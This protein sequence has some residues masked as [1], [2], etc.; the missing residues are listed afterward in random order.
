MSGQGKSLQDIYDAGSRKLDE[1]EQTE[2]SKLETNALAAVEELGKVETSI[3][4]RMERSVGELDAEIRSYLDK[5]VENIKTAVS[6]EVEENRKFLERLQEALKLSCKSLSED[7]KQL[8]ESMMQRFDSTAD[9]YMTLQKRELEKGISLLKTEGS[10]SAAKLKEQSQSGLTAF[11]SRRAGNVLQILD[12]NIKVP[13]EFFAEFSRHAVSIDK[14]INDCL[15]LLSSRSKEISQDLNS[16]GMEMQRSLDQVVLQLVAE[17]ED[18]AKKSDAQLRKHCEDALSQALMYQEQISTKLSKELQ[19]SYQSSGSGIAEKMTAL[20]RDTDKLLE[21]VKQ[22][23]TDVDNGVRQNCTELGASFETSLNERLA[24]AR[25]HNKLV[26]D[27]RNQLM[28]SIAGD[29][30]EIESNFESRL[31]ELAQK[32][33]ARLSAVCVDAEVAITSAH[34]ACAAEFKSLSSQQQKTIEEKT[35]QLLDE[36]ETKCNQA[37]HTIKIAA[38]DNTPEAGS[39]P[40]QQVSAAEQTAAAPTP[41]AAE[42][43][44]TA[45]AEQTQKASSAEELA[46]KLFEDFGD[47][48]L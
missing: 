12:K 42:Q 6:S 18:V 14:R 25:D 16:G 40:A 13:S 15:Q 2:R 44:Q 8:R 26:S 24:G 20:S 37:I 38:G 28:I 22:L 39:A 34:D 17:M 10:A 5:A 11:S 30:K 46:S 29:L 23:L 43:S 19:D 21:Q 36:I 27:E 33:Q 47:L 45:P 41:A 7:V 1:F 3:M 35:Q 9:H 4:D 31:N 48:K 32:C